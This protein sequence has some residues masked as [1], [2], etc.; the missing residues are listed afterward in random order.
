MAIK[1]RGLVVVLAGI[2]LMSIVGVVLVSAVTGNLAPLQTSEITE[3]GI[4][5]HNDAYHPT[6]LVPA[7]STEVFICGMLSGTTKRGAWFNV[8]SQDR[9][10][11]QASTTLEPGPFFVSSLQWFAPLTAGDYRIEAGYV[12]PVVISSNFSV[13]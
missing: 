13:R 12:R 6:V 1:L 11:A 8:F 3:L 10:V 9:V 5:L 4:C 2:F 7:D